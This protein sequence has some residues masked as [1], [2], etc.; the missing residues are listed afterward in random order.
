MIFLDLDKR[1]FQGGIACVARQR[2]GSSSPGVALYMKLVLFSISSLF[3]CGAGAAR[4]VAAVTAVLDEIGLPLPIIVN[5]IP[6]DRRVGCRDAGW[7]GRGSIKAQTIF[8]LHVQT[9]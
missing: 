2:C 8:D 3:K 9:L 6:P 4:E 5:I 1:R 7:G